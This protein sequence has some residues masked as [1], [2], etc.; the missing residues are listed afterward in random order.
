MDAGGC[1]PAAHAAKHPLGEDAPGERPTAKRRHL[2]GAAAA[3]APGCDDVAFTPGTRGV[4]GDGKDQRHHATQ[5]QQQQLQHA[6]H[7]AKPPDGGGERDQGPA[8]KG[9]RWRAL[10]P[11]ISW[12]R[13]GGGGGGKG[14]AAGEERDVDATVAVAALTGAIFSGVL[15]RAEGGGGGQ[16]AEVGAGGGE[17]AAEAARAERQRGLPPPTPCPSLADPSAQSQ[18]SASLGGGAGG[19]E[20]AAS[21]AAGAASPVASGGAPRT[22]LRA[23]SGGSSVGSVGAPG[24]EGRAPM[25]RIPE[26]SGLREPPPTPAYSRAGSQDTLPFVRSQPATPPPTP[27]CLSAAPS[28]TSPLLGGGSGSGGGGALALAAEGAVAAAAATAAAARLGRGEGSSSGAPSSGVTTPAN[29]PMRSL[30]GGHEGAGAARPARGGAGGVS[31]EQL[32]SAIGDLAASE[33]REAAADAAAAALAAPCPQP[34]A[35]AP[36]QHLA[37]GA[38]TPPTP[39]LGNGV[40]ASPARA[41]SGRLPHHR[42]AAS[43]IPPIIPEDA[44]SSAGDLPPA[45]PPPQPLAA[46]RLHAPGGG[47]G[48]G[49]WALED[50]LAVPLDEMALRSASR[51]STPRASCGGL[52][53]SRMSNSSLG[54]AAGG[55]DGGEL[56]GR[57]GSGGRLALL[58]AGAAGLQGALPLRSPFQEPAAV[59]GVQQSRALSKQ[60]SLTPAVPQPASSPNSDAVP[61]PNHAVTELAACGVAGAAVVV[62]AAGDGGGVEADSPVA[63]HSAVAREQS[64]AALSRPPS[65]LNRKRDGLRRLLWCASPPPA[66]PTHAWPP[67]ALPWQPKTARVSV[68]WDLDNKQPLAW[69]QLPDLVGNLRR[70]LTRVGR[71]ARMQAWANPATYDWVPGDD[72]AAREA[73]RQTLESLLVET[74]RDTEIR[75]QMCGRRCKS[76]AAL[77]KH[78]QQLHAREHTKRIRGAP[79]R[80]VKRYLGSDKVARYRAAAE[81]AGVQGSRKLSNKGRTV[82]ALLRALGV[83]ARQVPYGKDAADR[84]L[85]DA[86][87]ALM[88]GDDGAWRPTPLG[89][90]PT[91]GGGGDGGAAGDDVLAVV[92]DDYGFRGVMDSARAAGWRVVAVCSGASAPKFEGAA[93]AVLPWEAVLPPPCADGGGWDEA[94]ADDDPD[95][96]DMWW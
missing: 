54:S 29:T 58:G 61:R 34:R 26:G 23:G 64:A 68:A 91:F 76:L 12:A 19:D 57:S 86:V 6:R 37:S 82:K 17:A 55:C 39:P 32:R 69:A 45:P 43:D 30:S 81:A 49:A 87:A 79:Q 60:L 36:P 4:P 28:G 71:V 27:Q 50:A 83:R 92:S 89:S 78:F 11:L 38:A 95:Q 13:L 41:L 3:A 48:A 67:A 94:E 40:A 8:R 90:A 74:T 15:A 20:G 2:D 31:S 70:E 80:A 5:Q 96:L 63:A 24:D 77:E 1:A 33:E 84:A 46:L 56:V 42:S 93:D 65:L 51:G 35:A 16:E 25:P 47:C 10:S 22:P 66:A 52:S 44:P 85:A 9:G 75:C 72:R 18:G 7:G 14:P 59:A 21:P 62:G 88:A 53:L 73:E